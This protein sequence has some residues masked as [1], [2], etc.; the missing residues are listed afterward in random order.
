MTQKCH[1]LRF[2]ADGAAMPASRRLVISASVTGSPEYL[3]MLRRAKMMSSLGS[4]V[5]S[6]LSVQ[7]AGQIGRP[8]WLLV[9]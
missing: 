6:F 9:V 3:R 5:N 8:S 1:G 2:E 4:T 7:A